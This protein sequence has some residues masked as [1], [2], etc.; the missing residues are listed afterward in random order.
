MHPATFS[1]SPMAS[2]KGPAEWDVV[3][4]LVDEILKDG[5]ITSGDPILLNLSEDSDS[6]AGLFPEAGTHSS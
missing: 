1:Y 3:E 2:V 4:K 6:G 5:F